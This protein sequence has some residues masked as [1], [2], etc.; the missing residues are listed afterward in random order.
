MKT[1]GY[2]VTITGVLPVDVSSKKELQKT[3]ALIA[4]AEQEGGDVA[5]VLKR[6]EDVSVQITDSSKPKVKRKAKAGGKKRGPKPKQAKLPLEPEAAKPAD[7]P[8][9]ND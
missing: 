2:K 1:D 7:P 4:A 8:S 6:L 3:A 5:G 9:N